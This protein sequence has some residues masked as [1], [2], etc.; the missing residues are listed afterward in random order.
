MELEHIRYSELNK[1]A[2]TNGIVIFG[3]ENDKN[4][5]VRMEQNIYHRKS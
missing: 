4:I 5:P 1:L 2:E 3:M